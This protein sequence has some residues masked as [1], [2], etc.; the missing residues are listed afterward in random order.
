MVQCVAMRCDAS[1]CVAMRCDAL[2]CDALRCV[3]LRCD[4]LRAH[5]R[6]APAQTRRNGLD[7]EST[8]FIW[9][10]RIPRYTLFLPGYPVYL[11]KNGKIK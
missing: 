8:S 10:E 11:I 5:L 3:A 7:G 1:R 2:R 9:C 6:C 4:A